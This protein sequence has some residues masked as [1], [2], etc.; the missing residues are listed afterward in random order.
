MCTKTSALKLR[1]SSCHI[2]W[3]VTADL[4]LKYG[5]QIIFCIFFVLRENHFQQNSIKHGFAK[6]NFPPSFFSTM[7]HG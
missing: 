7:V 6:Q 5:Q 3:Q 2:L 4:L 1:L